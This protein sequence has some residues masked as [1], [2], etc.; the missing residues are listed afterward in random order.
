[1]ADDDFRPGAK[2]ADQRSESHAK[3][4]DAEQ[5]EFRRLVGCRVPKPPACIVFAESRRLHERFCLEGK[6]VR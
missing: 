6:T 4:L 1:M 2:A 5:V 3:R